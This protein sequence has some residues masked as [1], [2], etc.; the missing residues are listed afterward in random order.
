[1]FQVRRK[2][3]SDYPAESL[4][5]LCIAL[6]RYIRYNCKRSDLNPF[7]R[8]NPVFSVFQQTLIGRI[9]ELEE[10]AS[11]IAPAVR[12]DL[13]TDE[14]ECKL[15]QHVFQNYQTNSQCLSYAIY[16]YNCKEFGLKSAEEHAGV[17]TSQY[18]S[19][20]N[21][22]GKYIQFQTGSSKRKNCICIRHMN[23]DHSHCFVRLFQYYLAIIPSSGPFYRRPLDGITSKGMPRFSRQKVGVHRIQG[24]MKNMCEMADIS[25]RKIVQSLK[26]IITY[27]S[28]ILFFQ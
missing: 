18:T 4:R 12:V 6:W 21:Q 20:E 7:N 19:D 2:D 27:S 25:G 11:H 8:D 15:W 9:K 16:Y 3:G 5:L 14:D 1:M 24:Y 10:K 13:I 23:S 17:E 26:V 28:F 22:Q